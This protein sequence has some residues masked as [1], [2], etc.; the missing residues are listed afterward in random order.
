MKLF[1]YSLRAKHG[2]QHRPSLFVLNTKSIH[3]QDSLKHQFDVQN[4][5]SWTSCVQKF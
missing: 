4:K 2:A 1:E 5:L 3:N